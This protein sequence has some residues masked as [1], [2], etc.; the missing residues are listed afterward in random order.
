MALS[1]AGFIALCVLAMTSA[2]SQVWTEQRESAG[3]GTSSVRAKS[4]MERVLRS[5]QD[6]GY[7]SAGST[8]EPAALLLWA[9]DDG[10]SQAE[11]MGDH[12]IQQCELM[13]IRHDP[14]TKQIKLYRGRQWDLLSSV[15]QLLGLDLVSTSAFNTRATADAFAQQTWVQ[16]HL[17][18]GGPGEEVINVQVN[19]DRSMDNPIVHFRYEVLRAGR[20]QTIFAIVSLRVPGAE[21]D[22]STDI[23]EKSL[24][25]TDPLGGGG[26]GGD[27]GLDF[28][29]DLFP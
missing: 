22:W 16:E 15:E 8:T 5:S 12:R 28:S 7:W 1:L 23:L 25:P 26:G 3:N 21:D 10:A 20:I 29:L 9:D 4:Y 24:E 17:L 6:V 2:S 19:V 14:E 11:A 27:G 13:L 18:A